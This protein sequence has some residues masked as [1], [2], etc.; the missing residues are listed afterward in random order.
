MLSRRAARLALKPPPR[1]PIR[2]ILTASSAGKPVVVVGVEQVGEEQA[3]D[4]TPSA[5]R[6]DSLTGGRLASSLAASGARLE[7]GK[8][9]LLGQLHEDI[10]PVV[11][12]GLGKKEGREFDSEEGVDWG[13]EAVRK[14]AA[15]GVR[16]AAELKAGEV[17]VE[18]FGDGEAAAEGATLANWKYD[19]FK[20][21]KKPLPKVGCLVRG[22]DEGE[23]D[24]EG[25]K[26]GEVLGNAQNLARRLMEAPASFLTPTQFCE[27]AK[28]ALEG[29][30]VQVEVRDK[31][32]A[33]E[34]GM[35]SFLS[36]AQGSA[37]PPKFLELHYK[38][39]DEGAP[40]AVFVGKGVTFDTGG[41]SIKPSAK[42]DLMRGDMGGAAV[43]TSCM[44]AVARLG[45]R[46]NLTVLVPLT[47]NMPGSR[48]T[49]P[50][51]VVTAMNGKTIQ[52]EA[53]FV[54]D[55]AI[56]LTTDMQV[57]NTDAEGRLI[58]A[59]ALCYA[60]TLSPRLVS[61]T[62]QYLASYPI[63]STRCWTLLL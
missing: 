52:V 30:P 7:A 54:K 51:D 38:G 26:R 32:W 45:M 3:F 37:Q 44:T 43:V 55:I 40:P 23:G 61:H 49:R 53:V 63:N 41:I 9:R 14:A 16:A 28:Q 22:G 27:E 5:H 57:D 18:T 21:D 6:I 31:S 56:G 48:A 25:W 1:I 42:M 39:G 29:L 12:V 17:H 35:G 62:C 2:S 36:V 20:S 33:E 59:D 47:E 4:L 46:L 11:V 19:Q 24:G 15:S 8:S 60:D 34:K 13:R 50:G 58:L 10:G